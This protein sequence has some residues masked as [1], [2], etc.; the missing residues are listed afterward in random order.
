[1]TNMNSIGARLGVVPATTGVST[2][3]AEAV[4]TRHVAA[5]NC[6]YCRELLVAN[7]RNGRF[8][9]DELNGKPAVPNIDGITRSPSD[10]AHD[11]NH[12]TYHKLEGEIKDVRIENKEAQDRVWRKLKDL[13]L[14]GK[15]LQDQAKIELKKLAL[16]P[17]PRLDTKTM[18]VESFIKPVRP[19]AVKR[20]QPVKAVRSPKSEAKQQS[21]EIEKLRTLEKLL[22][23][24]AAHQ[25]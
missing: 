12:L 3:A 4:V 10:L 19:V 21:R 11:L 2:D 24:A 20:V 1:M 23:A 15:R 9:L 25:L 13:G 17:L 16:K 8:D 18:Y 5:L 14:R 7:A 6:S 22:D